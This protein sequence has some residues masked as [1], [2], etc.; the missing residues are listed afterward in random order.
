MLCPWSFNVL[1]TNADTQ[2]YV[3][4]LYSG[5]LIFGRKFE[6]VNRGDLYLG[7]LYL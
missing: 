6:L 1:T 7:G 4:G 5:G 3:L 2:M